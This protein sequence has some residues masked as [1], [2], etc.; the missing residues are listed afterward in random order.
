M[1]DLI[2]P[3]FERVMNVYLAGQV[4]TLLSF[5]ADP[6]GRGRAASIS[7]SAAGRRCR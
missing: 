2:V 7:C 5:A 4:Y 1:M 3:L 6:F